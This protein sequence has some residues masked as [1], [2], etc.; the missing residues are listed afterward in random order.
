L[1]AGGEQRRG[2]LQVAQASVDGEVESAAGEFAVQLDVRRVVEDRVKIGDVQFV[3]SELGADCFSD[4]DDGVRRR[5][6]ALHGAVRIPF[7]RDAADDDAVP[8][9]DDWNGIQD[10]PFF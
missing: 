1:N 8:D 7:P 5:Q 4:V 9:V 10:W 2:T 3:Q 6:P